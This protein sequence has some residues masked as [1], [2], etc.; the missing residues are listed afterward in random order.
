MHDLD[1]NVS[2]HE[3]CIVVP[4]AVNINRALKIVKKH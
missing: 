2:W 4:E 3:V 1:T